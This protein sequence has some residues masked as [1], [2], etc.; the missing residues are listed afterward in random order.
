MSFL[1]NKLQS[2][3]GDNNIHQQLSQLSVSPSTNGLRSLLGDSLFTLSEAMGVNPLDEM[4]Q[5]PQ[6]MADLQVNVNASWGFVFFPLCLY[7]LY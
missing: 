7:Y 5:S 1:G 4:T 2:D 6:A 3:Q